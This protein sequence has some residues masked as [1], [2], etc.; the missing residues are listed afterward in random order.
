ME[1]LGAPVAP[2]ISGKSVLFFVFWAIIYH[3]IFLKYFLCLNSQKREKKQKQAKNPQKAE[4]RK[5]AKKLFSL[6]LVSSDS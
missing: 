5:K 1:R 4:T 3:H 6:D 2:I